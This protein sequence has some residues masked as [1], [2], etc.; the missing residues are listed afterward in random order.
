M[1]RRKRRISTNVEDLVFELVTEQIVGKEDITLSDYLR[2][3]IIKDLDNRDML[4]ELAKDL[5]I[6]G[7]EAL[8][9]A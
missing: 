8:E 2:T 4:P 5:L 3:L 9:V 7:I 6:M 1:E